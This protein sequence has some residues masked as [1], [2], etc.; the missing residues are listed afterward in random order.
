[1][2]ESKGQSKAKPE[3]N[4]DKSADTQIYAADLGY[5]QTSHGDGTPSI[6]QQLVDRRQEVKEYN[7]DP[8]R[9]NTELAKKLKVK[10]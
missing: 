5:S 6:S 10:K 9:E 2:S 4:V 1:M 3:V 8:D 7:A